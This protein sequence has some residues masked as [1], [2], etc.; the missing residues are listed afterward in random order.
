MH[1]AM[2]EDDS[3]LNR[4]YSRLLQ[5][6]G[7]SVSS[8]TGGQHFLD[9]AKK[10]GVVFDLV[11]CDYRLPETDGFTLYSA[12]KHLGI[13]CP[14]VLMSAYADFDVAVK[15]LKAGIS[16]FLIKP[17]K[18]EILL[19]KVSSYFQRRT[20]EQELLIN[21]LGKGIVAQSSMMQKILQKLART[22]ESKASILLSGES[23]TGKEVVARMLHQ[24]SPRHAGTFVAVNVSA[25]PSTL[26]EAEFF[27]YRKG[28]FTDAIRDHEGFARMADEGTLFLDEIGELSLAA[29]A[30]LL[31]L[32]EERKVQPLGSKDVFTVNF[33]LISATNKDLKQL[34]REGRFRDDLYYRLAVISVHIPP[35][36]ERPEDVVPLARFLLMGIT[37][38]ESLDILDFTPKAQEKLLSYSWPG[39]VRELKNRIHEA[40]LATDEKWIDAHHLNLPGERQSMERPLSYDKAR[41]K[42]EKRYA[43]RLLRATRGNVNRVSELSGLSRKAVY[44]LMKRHNI[45]I[46]LFRK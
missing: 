28:A 44:D 45:D 4:F 30:K 15:V 9:G 7:Y 29:Q 27:G 36:R 6:E 42:F 40:V 10:D 46:Q 23:G 14:F 41:A 21:K 5:K 22:A 43:M 19:Q 32:L 37:Q 18:K 34:V 16:D 8:Y 38:E 33:R 31:R 17:V 39:N 1:I 11:I 2:I 12:A 24:I 20:L 25:I 26:F 3:D 13:Q 35:L